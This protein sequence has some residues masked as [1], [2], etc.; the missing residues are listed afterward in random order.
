MPECFEVIKIAEY[1]QD[2]GLIGSRIKDLEFLNK[3]D[4][5]LKN[6]SPKSFIERIKNQKF[7]L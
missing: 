4:R 5:L 3:G 2:S 6:M 1:L 7:A